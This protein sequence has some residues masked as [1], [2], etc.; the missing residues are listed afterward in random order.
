MHL[1]VRGTLKNLQ[2]SSRLAGVGTL[3]PLL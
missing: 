1:L 3:D 2:Y